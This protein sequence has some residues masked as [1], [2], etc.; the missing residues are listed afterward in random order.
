M[1]RQRPRIRD[2]QWFYP[3]LEA[4]VF[5]LIG[6]GLYS[7]SSVEN[8]G[9]VFV[10]LSIIFI[11]H[12]VISTLENAK[13][14]SDRM[15]QLEEV[16]SIES[17]QINSIGQIVDLS[18]DRLPE[19]VRSLSSSYLSV[20]EPKLR[21]YKEA[22]LDEAISSI[23]NLHHTQKTPIL[24]ELEFYKW[25]KKE[26]D[27]AD[28]TTVFEIVSMDEELEWTDTPEEREFLDVNLRAAER[29][30]S[31]TRIFVFDNDRLASAKENKGIYQH[32]ANSRTRLKGFVVDRARA[33]RAAPMAIEQAGQGFIIVNRKRVIVDRFQNNEARGFVTFE[34]SEVAKYIDAYEQ[35]DVAKVPLDFRTLALPAPE[36]SGD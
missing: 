21:P 29:G 11:I 18:Q 5:F 26:F 8:L 36:K 9:L 22:I 19:R 35:F 30:A 12:R 16:L 25:L 7:F 17:N 3:T 28:E 33:E 14:F 24:Q 27:E 2:W 34:P 20:T 4:V 1:T 10:C 32:R 23:K 6:A 31:I 13:M 15:D